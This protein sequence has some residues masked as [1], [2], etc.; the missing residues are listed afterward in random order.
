MPTDILLVFEKRRLANKKKAA[1]LMAYL[2]LVPTIACLLSIILAVESP[3]Y[4][5]ALTMIGLN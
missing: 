4:A 2:L 1:D 3:A 5:V